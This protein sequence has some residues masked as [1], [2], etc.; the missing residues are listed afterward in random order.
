MKQF[1]FFAVV[2]LV[3]NTVAGLPVT[4]QEEKTP[5]E[6]PD[7]NDSGDVAVRIHYYYYSPITNKLI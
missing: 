4:K 1:I 6:N 3:I 7:H 5:N 2:V